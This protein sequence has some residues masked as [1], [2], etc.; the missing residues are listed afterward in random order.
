MKAILVLDEMPNS[1][2]A[3]PLTYID[4]G[5]DAYY[6]ANTTRCVI[7]KDTIPHHGKW[8]ECPLKDLPQKIVG[9]REMFMPTYSLGWNDCI[10]TMLGEEEGNNGLKPLKDENHEYYGCP[11]CRHIV[12][13][14]QNYCENCGQKLD[15]R[16]VGEIE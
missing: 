1:C 5:D 12:S 16:N 9:K 10:G 8:D 6:G 13:S 3:C 7:D 4:Y 15:W 2:Y 14:V 11:S